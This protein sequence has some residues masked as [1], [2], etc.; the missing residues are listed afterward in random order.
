MKSVDEKRG[1]YYDYNGSLQNT[2]T[3]SKGTT[4]V[5][6]KNHTSASIIKERLSPT[7]NAWR[8]NASRSKFVKKVGVPDRIQSF[9]EVD[10]SKNGPRCR[11]GFVKPIRNGL[12]K[13]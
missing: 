12:R 6:L 7:S 13:S 4:F 9:G 3:N 1:K 10:R 5:V 11:P 2:S 8:R